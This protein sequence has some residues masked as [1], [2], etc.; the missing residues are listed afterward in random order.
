MGDRAVTGMGFE[1]ICAKAAL[2]FWLLRTVAFACDR[3]GELTGKKL[4][5]GWF[6]L[7]MLTMHR[8]FRIDA[9]HRDLGYEPVVS[10]MEAWPDTVQWFNKNWLPT[11]DP[12]AASGTTGGIATQTAAKVKVQE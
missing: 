4:K 5:L 3:I 7:R 8:W 10:Y 1:S 11:F 9:A 2:P 12:K 6:T